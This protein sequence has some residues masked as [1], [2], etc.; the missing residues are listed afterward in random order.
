MFNSTEHKF[1]ASWVRTAVNITI[2]VINHIRNNLYGVFSIF[3]N[4]IKIPLIYN[5]FLFN[6][7]KLFM[8]A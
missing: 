7:E 5:V 1:S 4:K 6:I 2:L 8:L 3:L